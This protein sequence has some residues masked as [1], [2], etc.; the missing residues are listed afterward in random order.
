[1]PDSSAVAARKL[2]LAKDCG[3]VSISAVKLHRLTRF[4]ILLPVE[5]YRKVCVHGSGKDSGAKGMY[6]T[7]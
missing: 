5:D 3:R 7:G 2:G 1:M 6:G 4:S